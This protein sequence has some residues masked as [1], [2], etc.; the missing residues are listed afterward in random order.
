M[1]IRSNDDAPVDLVIFDCDGVLVDSERLAVRVESRLLTSLGWPLTEE[2]VLDRFV[3]RSDAY[4]LGEIERALG[5]TVPEWDERYRS[6]LHA[7]FHDE[8]VAVA[9][10]ADA[11]DQLDVATCVASSGTHEKMRLTLGLTGLH[12]RFEGRIYSST[13]VANS[14]PAPDLFLF[15]A[16]SMGVDPE[17]CL[18]VEDSRSGV[19]AARAAGMRSIGYAGGL[20]PA[21]WLDGTGTTVIT[22]MAALPAIVRASGPA[23]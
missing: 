2:E 4:M 23:R 8:L 6:D 18:V 13:Q 1:T 7:A 22:D 5:R 16:R 15:A 17:W 20:T 11:I 19:E 21:A 14:K 12:D 3:G 10:V 9:G